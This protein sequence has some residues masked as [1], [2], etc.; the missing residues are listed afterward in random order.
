MN[1]KPISVEEYKR[2]LACAKRKPKRK[3]AARAPGKRRRMSPAEELEAQM[4]AA[5]LPAWTPEHRFHPT[6]RWRLD[7]AWPE[8]LLAVEVHG[9]VW[10]DGRHTRG[11]GFT[12]DREKMNEAALLGWRVL[13][14]TTDHV[15]SGQALSWVE[16]ALEAEG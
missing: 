14:V 16:Q 13:E 11:A 4:R 2:L 15:R 8:R 10:A 12:G 6:R 7:Y 9:G 3:K 5:G 1:P